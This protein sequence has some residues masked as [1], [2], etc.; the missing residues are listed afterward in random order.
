[1][2]HKIIYRLWI[3]ICLINGSLITIHSQTPISQQ[4]L[5]AI[6]NND[7]TASTVEIDNNSPSYGSQ[8][9]SYLLEMDIDALSEHQIR[10]HKVNNTDVSE[11]LFTIEKSTNSEIDIAL[12]FTEFNELNSDQ[13]VFYFSGVNNQFQIKSPS[14]S[15]QMEDFT[16]ETI[17]RIMMCPTGIGFYVDNSLKIAVPFNNVNI[18]QYEAFVENNLS[19]DTDVFIEFSKYSSCFNNNIRQK[20]SIV[21]NSIPTSITKTKNGEL[22]FYY[23]EKYNPTANNDK[24]E[25]RFY[26]ED[27]SILLGNFL[28]EPIVIVKDRKRGSNFYDIDLRRYLD[29]DDYSTYLMEVT[30]ANKNLTYYLLFSQLRAD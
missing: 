23:L 14:Y 2:Q 30:Q 5:E 22:N 29:S 11:L 25:I 7:G 27:G 1:M 26:K 18:I 28:P 13:Y 19:V 17:F 4:F 24:I 12:G 21:K 16:S 9:S 8:S 3:I 10:L 20:Y 15:S 6:L